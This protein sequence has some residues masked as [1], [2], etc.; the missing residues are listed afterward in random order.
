MSRSKTAG[1]VIWN[2][3]LLFFPPPPPTP[4]PP[5]PPPSSSTSSSSL[6]S[7]RSC[8]L[9]SLSRHAVPNADTMRL[10]PPT[11]V[12]ED[13]PNAPRSS[14]SRRRGVRRNFDSPPFFPFRAVFFS[15]PDA[16]LPFPSIRS[17]SSSSTSPP[18]SSSSAA[19]S[20]P[21]SSPSSSTSSSSSPSSPP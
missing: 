18:S 20:S 9:A 2:S 16:A 5:C 11:V 12:R 19:S 1:L 17:S 8:R 14:C 6:P 4:L 21:S 15:P 3:F 7:S 10:S 13:G